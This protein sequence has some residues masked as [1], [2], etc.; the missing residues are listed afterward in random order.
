MKMN[1][2]EKFA[3]NNPF[4]AYIQKRYEAPLLERLGGRVEGMRVL[5]VGC[6]SGVGTELIFNRFGAHE[7]HSF[8][9]DPD[10]VHK[11]RK[12][13]SSFFPDRLILRVGDVTRIDAENEMYDAV[14]DFWILHHVPQ[15]QAGVAEIRRVLKPG[16]RFFFQ[17]VT[18]H[19]LNRW[20][21]RLFLDHPAENR[22]SGDEFISELERHGIMVGENVILRFFGDFIFGVGHR[23]ETS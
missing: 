10:M 8:D 15:W 11:A 4:R 2:I 21:Y 18:S 5:E 22:F 3:M 7:V 6:G 9:I 12:R 14:F 13:L 16:G 1:R 23:A 19:A 20:S 17:E